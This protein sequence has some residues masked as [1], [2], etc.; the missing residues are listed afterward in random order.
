VRLVFDTNVLIAAFMTSSGHCSQL[1]DHCLR[2]HRFVT[3]E[4][5]LGELREKLVRKFKYSPAEASAAIGF[6]VV[7][8]ELVTPE[9]LPAPVCRDPDDDHVLATAVTGKSRC[10]VTG[11]RDLLTLGSHAGIAILSPRDFWAFE[12]AERSG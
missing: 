3:S 5:I 1:L 11:D 12:A 7:S 6:V 8:A 9:P 4:F 2:S 10:I